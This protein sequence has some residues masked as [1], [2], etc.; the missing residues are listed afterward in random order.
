MRAMVLCAGLGTRLRPLTER[1]PKPA[2]PFLGRPLLRFALAGLRAAGVT[3]VGIN[4]HHLPQV[5]ETVARAECEALG[6]DFTAVHEP[7]I[8]GTGGGIRGLRTFLEQGDA[9]VVNGDVLFA[10][11][12][13]RVLA[14]HRASGA[15]ATMVLLPMPENEK[16]NAV[17]C[18]ALMRVRRIAGVGA[19]RAG[20]SSWHFSGVHVLSPRAWSGF[21][22][23]PEDINRDVYPRFWAQG[24]EVHGFPTQGAWSDL[25]TP[26]RYLAAHQAVLEGQVPLAPFPGASPFD[27]APAL[28]QGFRAH[29]HPLAK[30]L[31]KVTGPAWVG[32][33]AT[34]EAGATLGASVSVGPGARVRSGA[35]LNRCAV[36]EGADVGPGLYEDAI[37]APGGV[38]VPSQPA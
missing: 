5:M 23:G 26:S 21:G 7:E 38:V 16:Y 27:D 32:P 9:L 28:A 22:H 30:V 8:Q 19:A 17:E 13:G 3:H 36:L 18:D 1:W 25:G 33:G 6:L 31:G 24:L 10:C 29:A 35:A 37:L 4:T 15:A 20:L 12:Y 34:L 2:I 11:D 14:A